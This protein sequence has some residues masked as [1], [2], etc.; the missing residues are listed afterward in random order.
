VDHPRVDVEP[1][2]S[3]KV[4]VEAV[5]ESTRVAAWREEPNSHDHIHPVRAI[6]ELRLVPG[7]VALAMLVEGRVVA[8]DQS[9]LETDRSRPDSVSVVTDDASTGGGD[10]LLLGDM[11]FTAGVTDQLVT[12]E[13]LALRAERMATMRQV[14]TDL[15]D[16]QLA[17]MTEPVAEPGYPEP[18][19]FPVRRCLQVIL[20]EE[21]SHRLY[22]ERDLDVLDARSSQ[23]R[24]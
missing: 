5:D 4:E 17:G 23:V 9:G 1:V 3:S 15:T 14:I 20:N 2:N 22:A 13:V 16:E 7:R 18:E 24:R 8:V 11:D 21:W 10:D 19:S 12:S 6:L